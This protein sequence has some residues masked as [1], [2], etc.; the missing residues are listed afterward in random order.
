M[1]TE[2]RDYDVIIAGYGPVG[3]TA[4]NLLG[5]MGVRV[6]VVERD[7]SIFPRARAIS[8]DEET[9]RIWQGLGL[10][11]R[12]K[13]DMLAGL[14]ID[15]VDARGRSF[16]SLAPAPRGNG[17]PPQLFIYQPAMEQ[18]L[19]D[20]VDRYPNVEVLL[21]H[22]C[23]AVEQDSDSVTVTARDLTDDTLRTLRG[24]YLIAADG[25]SSP[26]R[27]QLGTGFDGR[28]YH[29]RWV[30][31]DTKVKRDW[32]TVDRL[33]FHCDPARPAVDCPTPLGHHR[34]EFPVLPGEDEQNLVSHD[35]IWRLLRRYGRTPDEVEIL[36]AVVYSH[37]VRFAE[38]WRVGRIFLAGD[39]AHAM[40]PWIGEGMSSGVRDAGNLCWKL[41][42]VLRGELPDD[43]LDSYEVERKPHVREM[44][45][46]AVRFGRIITERRPG[47]AAVRNAAFRVL[48]RVPAFRAYMQEAGWFPDTSYRK[49]L[50]DHTGG[51]RAVGNQLPQPWVQTDGGD[52]ARLDDVLAGRW[53]L[54]HTGPARP[55]SAWA[56]GAVSCRQ[57]TPAGSAPAP[58]TIVDSDDVLIPW[59]R[60][61]RA[62]VLALRPDAV[63]YA[64]ATGDADLPRPPF[65]AAPQAPVGEHPPPPAAT[66][67][68]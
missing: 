49:G 24:A 38:R 1:N 39:A 65:V 58:G 22:E 61:H 4:A 54:L 27:T 13:E 32:D 52:H 59:M 43:V 47:L 31:I 33:R 42:A 28:T 11:E 20:G 68:P 45:A 46:Q 2:L 64:A 6:A 8:T 26:I 37:H 51:N 55:W 60:Q 18:V 15:F 9:I 19:R 17:H 23:E 41:A 40:P 3:V 10:A 14:P 57:V 5:G 67:M 30:V 48:M 50:L 62:T 35:Y 36:R 66:A 56:A 7:A 12:L 53:T 16:L 44:T 29:D 34:W 25:G 21:G 63:V